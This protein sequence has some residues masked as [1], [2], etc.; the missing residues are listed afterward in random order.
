MSVNVQDVIDRVQAVLQDAGAIRWPVTTELLLWISDAQREI[1]LLKPDATAKT[2]KVKL[3]VGT[4]QDLPGEASRLLDV[5]RNKSSDQAAIPG[6]AIRRVDGNILDTSAPDWHSPGVSGDAAHGGVIK[7][8]V[9][10]EKAP[11]QYYV[12]PGV[13]TL[14]GGEGADGVFVD[15]CYSKIPDEITA[16]SAGAAPAIPTTLEV[17]DIY[18]NAVMNYT[19]YMAFQKDIESGNNAQRA[20]SHYQLFLTSVAQKGQIDTLT[21]P[22]VQGN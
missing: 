4:K 9:Y 6:R 13:S 10:D 15:I 21:N 3:A 18:Q 22:N 20:S 1:S 11:R 17:A 14:S 5:V 8:Y 2:A 16:V 12:Y 19:L 7:H